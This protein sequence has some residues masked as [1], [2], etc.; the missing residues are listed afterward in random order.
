MTLYYKDNGDGYYEFADNAPAG[1]YAHLTPCSQ[2][3]PQPKSSEQ[4]AQELEAA[5][6]RHIDAV[7][8][9]DKWD[10]R[11]TC[12]IRAGY[13][14]PWQNKA[15]AFGQW[16]DACYSHCIQV[17]NDVAAGTRTVPTEAELIAELPVMVWPV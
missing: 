1:W 17:Q 12:T 4:I 16:M 9:A 8:K 15:I 10:S 14:N 6:D 3:L 11:I 5:V 2:Q 13:P 7:A